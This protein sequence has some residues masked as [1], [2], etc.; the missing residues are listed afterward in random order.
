MRLIPFKAAHADLM[1]IRWPGTIEEGAASDEALT[2]GESMG[3]A[4]TLIC[5]GRVIACGGVMLLW[6]SVGEGWIL[7]S[8]LIDSHKL[9]FHRAVKRMTVD[10]QDNMRLTRVQTVVHCEF[11]E[12]AKWL[13]RL[14]FENEG[15]MR[16]YGVHGDDYWRYARVV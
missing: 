16:N 11:P 3:P 2:A 1:E 6:G 14:G 8:T 7:G 9:A 15:V 10:I 12:S 4:F 5:D 13:E